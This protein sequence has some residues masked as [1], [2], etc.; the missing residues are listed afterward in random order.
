[1]FLQ[2]HGNEEDEDETHK[3]FLF[4]FWKFILIKIN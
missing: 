4:Y 2:E 3:S 1:V